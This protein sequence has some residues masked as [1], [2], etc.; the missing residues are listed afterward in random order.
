MAL[1]SYQLV[2]TSPRLG[3]IATIL[4]KYGFD[5]VIASIPLLSGTRL[6]LVRPR[7]ARIEGY[8]Q[9]ERIRM[10]IEEGGPTFIKLA[11]LLSNRPDVVPEQL[12]L[13]LR[14]LQ[15]D[16]PPFDL[17]T[18]RAIIKDET[19]YAV[20][21]LFERFEEEP[22]GA[23]SIG[24]VYKARLR[25]GTDVVVKVQRP[26]V[27]TK[28][29][30]D[31]DILRI[32]VEQGDTFLKQQ[33]VYNAKDILDA[34]ERSIQRELDYTSEARYMQQFS[35]FYRK[36]KR[37]YIPEVYRQY[38]TSRVLVMEYI[39]GSKI[40]D[41]AA[42]RANG[43]DPPELTERGM[44]VYLMQIFEHGYFHA[45]PH[46]GNIIVQPDGTLTLIDF[47]MIGKL[48]KRD[49]LNF[50][51]I[52]IGMAQQDVTRMA[53]SFRRLAIDPAIEDE[54]AFRA[55]VAELID[56]FS[57]LEVSELNMNELAQRLQA[58][59]RDHRLRMPG[60]VFLVLRAL[61]LLEGI[62]KEI[63]PNFKTYEFFKPYGRKLFADIY[64]PKHLIKELYD[65]LES[66]YV[67]ANSFPIEVKRILEKI[68]R[69][70]LRVVL[71][72]RS[73]EPGVDKLSRSINRLGLGFIVVGL[74]IAASLVYHADPA[75]DNYIG[76]PYLSAVGYVLAAAMG[77]VWAVGAFWNR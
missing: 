61:T 32:M 49:R 69:D 52:L 43:I 56:D 77:T 11:Q 4:L 29:Q 45:D 48:T 50:A 21:E 5:T 30:R 60:S 44:D 47:G 25:D 34:F 20:E 36:E 19:G 40:T 74:L 38:S 31:L 71:D 68:R 2:K 24:Q 9:W 27:Q 26:G 73:Y 63:H 12:M 10:A 14:K 64:N 22:I 37:F 76:F 39:A 70:E 67:F 62:G 42:L 57:A 23:A 65:N 75:P 13:E 54:R 53:N 33:G 15:N 1:L 41:V 17:E 72:H 28:V 55:D 7:G 46:P 6:R 35:N 51:G 18:A 16:V 59:I 8:T 58:V 3:Q 66:F